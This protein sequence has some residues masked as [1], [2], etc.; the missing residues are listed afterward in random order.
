[1]ITK[2]CECCGKEKTEQPSYFERLANVKNEGK[3]YCNQC[4]KDIS[5]E[6]GGLGRPKKIEKV[7]IKCVD[8]WIF[9]QLTTDDLQ[10]IAG[11]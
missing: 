9:L 2:K 8:C 11:K 4:I 10:L 3:Y 7:I 5:G 1:M 6:V